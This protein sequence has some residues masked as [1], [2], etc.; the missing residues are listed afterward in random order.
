[1][2]L[3]VYPVAP[4]ADG[5]L[6]VDFPSGSVTYPSPAVF[7]K[8]VIV[9][10]TDTQFVCVGNQPVNSA[11]AHSTVRVLQVTSQPC[12][13]LAHLSGFVSDVSDDPCAEVGE[14]P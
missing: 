14:T 10:Q 3:D 2:Q 9:H 4:D 12:C 1:M 6:C 7:A 8:H 11:E 13:V 5:V